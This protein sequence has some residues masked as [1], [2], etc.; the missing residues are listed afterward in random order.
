[1]WAV[2]IIF[3]R[4]FFIGRHTFHRHVYLMWIS[5]ICTV[6]WNLIYFLW[7]ICTSFS[8]LRVSVTFLIRILR[9]QLFFNE[10]ILR[11]TSEARMWFPTILLITLI[12]KVLWIKGWFLLAFLFRC[13]LNHFSVRYVPK[14]WMHLDLEHIYVSLFLTELSKSK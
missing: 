13:F 3:Y 6:F 7:Y 2:S 10:V 8:L 12:I 14:Q 1:M 9:F 11:S 4:N 5:L